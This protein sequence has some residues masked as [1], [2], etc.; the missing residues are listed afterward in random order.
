V[1]ARNAL[2]YIVDDKSVQLNEAVFNGTLQSGGTVETFSTVSGY[3][4]FD[5]VRQDALW[6]KIVLVGLNT[7]DEVLEMH[8]TL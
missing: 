3:K 5:D 4:L 8:V 1:R 6:I 7:P 2:Y